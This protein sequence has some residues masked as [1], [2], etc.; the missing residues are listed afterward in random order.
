MIAAARVIACTVVVLCAGVHLDVTYAQ[1]RVWVLRPSQ[2][3][4]SI[5]V[6]AHGWSTP[7]PAGFAAWIAHL[8][9]RGSI[10]VYPS[11]GGSPSSGLAVFRAGLESAFRSIGPARLPVVAL[12]KSFGGSAVFYYAAEARAWHV[13]APLAIV[14]V[15]PALPI[16]GLPSGRVPASTYVRILVGDADTIAGTAGADAFWRWLGASPRRRYVVVRSRPGFVANHDSAQR[17]DA[18][19]QAV[20]WKPLDALIARVVK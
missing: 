15:F 8:R 4:T 10:V 5:V 16:G 20:F 12:G 7:V 14:S 11:Y 2:K 18:I 9:A 17:S 1:P 6:F 13:P 19:A 3:A